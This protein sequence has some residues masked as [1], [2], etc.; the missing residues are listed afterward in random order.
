MDHEELDLQKSGRAG[1]VD[2]S[3][4]IGL[5]AVIGMFNELIVLLGKEQVDDDVKKEYN[6]AEL[7]RSNDEKKALEHTIEDRETA[8]GKP[9]DH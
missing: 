2:P 1:D 7:D 3:K 9:G 8:T 6:T 5:D 4:K